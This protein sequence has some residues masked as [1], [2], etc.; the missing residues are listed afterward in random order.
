VKKARS[1]L[2]P[3][4]PDIRNPLLELR[5]DVAIASVL[6]SSTG[7][8]PS[9]NKAMGPAKEAKSKTTRNV[10][11]AARAMVLCCPDPI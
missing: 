1:W 2:D 9:S 10:A 6:S 8:G 5:P 11:D 3:V 4:P 7:A